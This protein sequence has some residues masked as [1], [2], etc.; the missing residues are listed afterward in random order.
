MAQPALDENELAF[1]IVGI[2]TG[3]LAKNPGAAP[4]KFALARD[5]QPDRDI[6]TAAREKPRA[7]DNP[8]T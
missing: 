8:R 5:E 6:E 7:A 3:R 1:Q 4:E 2:A